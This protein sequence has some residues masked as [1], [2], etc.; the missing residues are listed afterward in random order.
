MGVYEVDTTKMDTHKADMIYNYDYRA[1]TDSNGYLNYYDSPDELDIVCL[2]YDEISRKFIDE[3]GV[4]IWDIFRY[5]TPNDLYLF[6]QKKECMVI[7]WRTSPGW[8]IELYY[9]VDY[10]SEEII[11]NMRHLEGEDDDIY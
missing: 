7:P 1:E 11:H 3:N 10:D 6:R 4:M 2:F 5:I 9:P 8:L